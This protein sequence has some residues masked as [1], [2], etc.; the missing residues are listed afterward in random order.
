MCV[1]AITEEDIPKIRGS[2][3]RNTEEFVDRLYEQYKLRE[4][5]LCLKGA[6]TRQGVEENIR[7]LLDKLEPGRGWY[8]G[9]SDCLIL[10]VAPPGDDPQDFGWVNFFVV[11][12]DWGIPVGD[13][14]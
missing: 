3:L 11:L 2:V 6:I 8:I 13:F 5:A 10:H 12:G 14:L 1:H 7:A 9:D 4:K